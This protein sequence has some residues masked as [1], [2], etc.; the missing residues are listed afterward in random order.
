MVR[1]A[2]SGK[3][4]RWTPDVV[5]KRIQSANIATY[6]IKHVQG[7]VELSNSQVASAV[8]LL[9]KV[10]PDLSAVGLTGTVEQHVINAKPLTP[11]AWQAQ[12]TVVDSTALPVQ[13]TITS[14]PGKDKHALSTPP[15]TPRPPSGESDR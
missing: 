3:N 7:K 4:S 14:D 5:R 1:V 2:Q 15:P 10:I 6:L 13:G 8:A 12:Y 9:K 11:E